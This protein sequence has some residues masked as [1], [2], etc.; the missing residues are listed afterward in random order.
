MI[1]KSNVRYCDAYKVSI[2]LKLSCHTDE[3][4]IPLRCHTD[5]ARIH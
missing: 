2:L 5:E 4:G 1:N 3:G